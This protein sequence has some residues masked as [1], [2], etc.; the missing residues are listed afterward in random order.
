MYLYHRHHRHRC[1][2]KLENAIV[3]YPS[4]RHLGVNVQPTGILLHECMTT[5]RR[6][7]YLII[8]LC[9]ACTGYGIRLYTI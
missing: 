2:L 1:S 4:T 7:T 9:T 8:P 6:D 3:G 5:V